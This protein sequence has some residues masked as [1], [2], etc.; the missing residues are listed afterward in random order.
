MEDVKEKIFFYI[1]PKLETSGKQN[2]RGALAAVQC[3]D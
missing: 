3:K 1:F 2:T